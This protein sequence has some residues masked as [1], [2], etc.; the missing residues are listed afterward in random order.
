MLTVAAQKI[1]SSRPRL[2]QLQGPLVPSS[3]SHSLSIFRGSPSS[4]EKWRGRMPSPRNSHSQMDAKPW[5][6][7]LGFA[8]LKSGIWL[9]AVLIT[10]S[11]SFWL[12][13]RAWSMWHAISSHVKVPTVL[14]SGAQLFWPLTWKTSVSYSSG[15]GIVL[16][17]ARA[18]E[19]VAKVQYSDTT[20]PHQRG[21]AM[22]YFCLKSWNT[23]WP[24]V[25]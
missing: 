1:L 15:P 3:A 5:R 13:E 12:K 17:L 7:K 16:G 8:N 21:I 22:D 10:V 2:R 25:V 14:V 19:Y 23:P 4:Y 20:H 24:C 11:G 9:N 6:Q 18:V